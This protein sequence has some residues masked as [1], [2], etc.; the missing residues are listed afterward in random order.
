MIRPARVEDVDA[1]VEMIHEL[2]EFERSPDSVEVDRD[3]LTDALFCDSPAV[4]ALVAEEEDRLSGMAIWFIN[5]STWTGRHGIALEDLFVRPEARGTGIGRQLIAELAT[6][7][8][9]SGY[10]RID[11]NVLT[12]N[13]RALRFYRSLG[14][15]AQD[16]WVGYRL[17]G[18]ALAA[19]GTPGRHGG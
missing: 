12:W 11:W 17:S 2:A 18:D 7:A 9:G 14:A 10:R 6:I 19:M 16:E 1:L 8:E 3:M 5:F 4:F 13:E 15:V